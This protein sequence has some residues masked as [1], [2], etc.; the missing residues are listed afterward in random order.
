MK[1]T[2]RKPLIVLVTMLVAGAGMAGCSNGVPLGPASPSSTQ[3]S[4]TA[5]NTAAASTATPT[6]APTPAPTT[7]VAYTPD[8][9]PVFTSDCTPC[10]GGSKPA[11]RYS[12]SSYNGVM[13]AVRAG[14][15][16]SP[17][18]VVTAPGGLM[19]GFLTGDRA[20]RSA[21][22]SRWVLAGAPAAR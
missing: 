11:A 10:H 19:Y 20:G 13:A 16:S 7:A 21:L 3:S 9:Q 22:I 8:L 14:S 12:T 15:S 17:L 4:S 2:L 5:S 18:V 1:T 6:P